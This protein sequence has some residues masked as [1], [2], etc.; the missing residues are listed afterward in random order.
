LTDYGVIYVTELINGVTNYEAGNPSNAYLFTL[1]YPD[2][3]T[4][5]NNTGVFDANIAPGEYLLEVR[6]LTSGC[7]TSR[8][9]VVQDACESFS[10]TSAFATPSGPGGGT[11]TGTVSVNTVGQLGALN[12]F[13]DN[14]PA[15]VSGSIIINVGAGERLISV[16]DTLT[17]CRAERTVNVPN[18]C[19]AFAITSV[20]VIAGGPG[21]G[22]NPPTGKIYNIVTANSQG[23][24]RYSLDGSTWTLPGD[25]LFENVAPGTY[26]LIAEDTVSGCQKTRTVEVP[27]AN[28][29]VITSIV[30]LAGGPGDTTL[31]IDP[32]GEATVVYA[33]I[34]GG[35]GD[36]SY[37]LDGVNFSTGDDAN[38]FEGLNVGVPYVAYVRDNVTG[39]IATRSFTVPSICPQLTLPTPLI[40]PPSPISASNGSVSGTPAHGGI[41]PYEYRL[42]GVSVPYDS[43]WGAT[44][45]FNLLPRGNYRYFVRD[46][47]TGCVAQLSVKLN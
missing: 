38:H 8:T 26:I 42:E 4:T 23:P 19:D 22:P 33:M 47:G 25:N 28:P 7:E 37:S 32:S 36:Y 1:T 41:G 24:V 5:S 40:T 39:L 27:L 9:V 10:I 14:A 31:G 20:S 29:P 21:F 3:T 2:N 30:T 18:A 35:S 43:G 13:V 46:M 45:T 6:D 44:Q 34:T 12:Y 15:T 17:G 11:P 16:E